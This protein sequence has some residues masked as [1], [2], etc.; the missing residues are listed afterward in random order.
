MPFEVLRP[1]PGVHHPWLTTSRPWPE[2][3]ARQPG[4]DGGR[5]HRPVRLP[6]GGRPG[7]QGDSSRCTSGGPVWRRWPTARSSAAGEAGRPGCP[8]GGQACAA[9]PG[10]TGV[11]P[12]GQQP[13]ATTGQR[14]PAVTPGA[15]TA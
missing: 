13:H 1:R 14:Q 15:N 5:C 10:P 6:A 2:H 9:T 8:Q 11:G 3:P 4:H 7:L 12:S